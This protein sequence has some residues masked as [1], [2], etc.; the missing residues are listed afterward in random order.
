[1]NFRAENLFLLSFFQNVEILTPIVTSL[2]QGG[3]GWSKFVYLELA[4]LEGHY[5]YFYEF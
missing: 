5:L 3:G 2:T 1:M 4:A